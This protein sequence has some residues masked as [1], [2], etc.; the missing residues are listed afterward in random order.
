[1]S[2]DDAQPRLLPEKLDQP[3]TAARILNEDEIRLPLLSQRDNL[4]PHLQY[5]PMP[6]SHM[7]E[8]KFL[9]ADTGNGN[10]CVVVEDAGLPGG[11]ARQ[12]DIAIASPVEGDWVTLKP[13]R[14]D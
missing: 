3:H 2:T 5:A 6:A 12:D 1:M 14:F 7:Q 9:V 8:V 11:I 4:I 13:S 10:G